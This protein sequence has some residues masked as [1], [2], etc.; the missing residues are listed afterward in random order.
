LRGYGLYLRNGRWLKEME[1]IIKTY[2]TEQLVDQLYM[3]YFHL[4]VPEKRHEYVA[5]ALKSAL[6]MVAEGGIDELVELVDW[7]NQ[8]VEAKRKVA[9]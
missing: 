3:N 7:T 2:T 5:Y 9:A 1:M 8:K 4:A 6:R